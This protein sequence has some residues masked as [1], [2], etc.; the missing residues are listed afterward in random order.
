M[1]NLTKEIVTMAADKMLDYP[2]FRIDGDT[3]YLKEEG[4]L[5][6]EEF[7]IPGHVNTVLNLYKTKKKQ[8]EEKL[9]CP[10]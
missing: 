7:K 9:K 4:G 2:S 3:I 1:N 5:E 8:K 10:K 6:P